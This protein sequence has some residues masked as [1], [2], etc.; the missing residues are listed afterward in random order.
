MN[1]KLYIYINYL[2]HRNVF[3]VIKFEFYINRYYDS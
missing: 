1:N 3:C 2:T